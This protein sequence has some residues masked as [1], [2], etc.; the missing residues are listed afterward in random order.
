[1]R[2]EKIIIKNYKSIGDT[3]NE[4]NFNDDIITIVGK[5]ESGKSNIINLFKYNH[6]YG[7]SED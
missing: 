4:I 3:D 6:S 2:Y 7:K 1:M 5:N